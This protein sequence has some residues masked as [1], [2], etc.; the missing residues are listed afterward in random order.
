MKNITDSIIIK[1]RLF[2][3]L[4]G[5][6]L[7][8][9]E[10]EKIAKQIG[11]DV[12]KTN[13]TKYQISLTQLM[14]RYK[15]VADKVEEVIKSVER[16]EM[17]RRILADKDSILHKKPMGWAAFTANFIPDINGLIAKLEEK[18][19]TLKKGNYIGTRNGTP[20]YK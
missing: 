8:K 11:D 16:G 6:D 5:L 13:K 19:E 3:D 12:S 1:S 2:N 18:H 17:E 9:S 4:T 20:V 15:L 14:T 7:D 10:I